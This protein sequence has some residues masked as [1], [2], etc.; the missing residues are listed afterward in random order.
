[1]T[2]VAEFFLFALGLYGLLL[3]LNN[4]VNV[5]PSE[6]K[7]KRVTLVEGNIAS[8]K[9][10]LV[11]AM[12]TISS[13]LL[14]QQ[15]Y[16]GELF[17]S[18]FYRYQKGYAFAL[19]M[20]Q[21]AHR[22]GALKLAMQNTESVIIDRSI[23]GDYAFALWNNAIGNL[24]PLQW[25]IYQEQAGDSISSALKRYANPAFTDIIIMFLSDTTDA[26][27]ERQ[28]LRDEKPIDKSY[29][30]GLETAHLIVMACVPDTHA[31]IELRWNDYETG[32]PTIPSLDVLETRR[33][34]LRARAEAAI[35]TNIFNSA[36]RNFLSEFLS[37]NAA[38]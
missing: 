20:T 23:L 34:T 16:V 25:K 32:A 7:K 37:N 31:I 26:C 6:K 9:T 33:Q 27:H 14:A 38:V 3:F 12:C 24:T 19:Q 28:K 29:M 18:T 2:V 1:M 10:T 4:V 22:L 21:H 36:A 30:L 17:L 15:E 13:S 11:R 35:E 5:P 8:G